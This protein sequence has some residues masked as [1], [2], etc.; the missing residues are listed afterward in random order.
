M[1]PC[2]EERDHGFTSHC[3]QTV[4]FF[5]YIPYTLPSREYS[6][7]VNTQTNGSSNSVPSFHKQVY[8]GLARNVHFRFGISITN[9]GTVIRQP[10][11]IFSQGPYL[12]HDFIYSKDTFIL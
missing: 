4:I 8:K 10:A 2:G 9:A 3:G 12:S 1:I 7:S 11:E 5:L 6:F